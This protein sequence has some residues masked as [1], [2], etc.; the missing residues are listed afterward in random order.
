MK[1]SPHTLRSSA[2]SLALGFFLCFGVSACSRPTRP[3]PEIPLKT[4]SGA[5]TLSALQ[6]MRYT[7]VSPIVRSVLSSAGVGFSLTLEDGVGLFPRPASVSPYNT[8]RLVPDLYAEGDL[9]G[10][11]ERDMVGV[12]TVGEGDEAQTEVVAVTRKDGRPVQLATFP[13]GSLSVK[14]L[15]TDGRTLIVE[16]F[17]SQ[18]NVFAHK[19]VHLTF[20]L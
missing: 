6:N 1:N 2:C 12:L 19:P 13:L 4:L 7:I 5:L 16:A 9:N 3:T 20:T 17:A 10:D 14:S 11:K 18:Q 15:R 8:V